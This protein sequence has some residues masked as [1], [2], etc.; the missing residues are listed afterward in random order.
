MNRIPNWIFRV[1]GISLLM[2]AV[3]C[4]STGTSSYYDQCDADV[5]ASECYATRRAPESEQVALA[6]DIALRWIEEHP[7]EE[8]I[9]DWGPGVLMFALTE[10]HRVTGDDRLRDYYSDWLDYHIQEGY[11]I[12]WSDSCPPAITAVSLLS[13]ASSDAYQRVVDDVLQYLRVDA[14]RT[15]YGG[16]SHTG[17]LG[18][19]RSIWVDSVF[20]FG[21]VLTRWGE[22]SGDASALDLLSEQMA[23]FAPRLQ[24]ENGLMQ[25]A[26]GWPGDVDTDIYWNRGNSWVTASLS[27]YLRVRLLRGESDAVVEKVFREQVSGALALQDSETGLWWTIM[28]RPGEIY[29]ETSG[30]ALFAYGMARAY[31]YGILG[32]RE[33]AAALLAVAGVKKRIQPD[34]QGRPVVT[35][36]SFGTDPTNF[37]GYAQVEQSDDVNYGVGAAILALIETSGLGD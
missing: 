5:P 8:Q 17:F 7:A 6:T 27:D 13:E 1:L 16:I 12:V 14:P 20:M 21:M 29:Q 3:Q 35:G 28:N 30:P 32:E 37:E 33:L 4:T 36:I 34:E 10:L 19:A 15:D 26:D 31:R 23:I 25:H 2:G 9:W 24:H 11:D 22:L 18:N